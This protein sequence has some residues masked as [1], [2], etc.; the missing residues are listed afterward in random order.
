MKVVAKDATAAVAS[1]ASICVVCT[2]Y[3]HVVQSIVCREVDLC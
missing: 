3:L 2:I 1:F